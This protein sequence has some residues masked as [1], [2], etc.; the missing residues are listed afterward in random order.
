MHSDLAERV[1]GLRHFAARR[2][3]KAWFSRCMRARRT[4]PDAPERAVGWRYH[5]GHVRWSPSIFAFPRQGRV[6]VTLS[7]RCAMI[8]ALGDD[9]SRQRGSPAR[10]LSCGR[11]SIFVRPHDV[12]LARKSI[13]HPLRRPW[14]A[15]GMV[16]GGDVPAERGGD[17]RHHVESSVVLDEEPWSRSRRSS[18]AASGGIRPHEL[19]DR[20][21]FRR[22]GSGY[23]LDG[24]LR[25]DA[26]APRRAA[27]PATTSSA[28]PRSSVA[29]APS[30][31]C[32]EMP[33][34]TADR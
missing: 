33:C 17:G 34:W 32:T 1:G 6:T 13:D 29:V 21:A 18:T 27:M 4:K 26:D 14:P 11:G 9:D 30:R 31:A 28:I 10:T 3:L 25:C 23:S 8:V 7:W 16:G 22:S 5:D 2:R 19:G 12:C 15:S 20:S 24:E